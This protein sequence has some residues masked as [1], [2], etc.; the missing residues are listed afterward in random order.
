MHKLILT[1]AVFAT[2]LM[3]SLVHAQRPG[4]EG[5]QRGGQRGEGAQRG[6]QRGG[7]PGMQRGGGRGGM[8]GQRPVSPLMTALDADKDGKLSKEEIANAAKALAA[9]DKNEDGVLDTSELAPARGGRGGGGMGGDVTE[10]VNE[11]FER[12]ANKDGKLSKEEGGEQMARWF[13]YVDN[14]GDGFVS[15]EEAETSMKRFSGGG[16]GGRGGGGR[17]GQP[18]PKS[19]ENRPAFDDN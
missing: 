16:R 11:M 18:T 10:R 12:D 6:G 14:D 15:R 7:G 5:G 1:L 19:K 17:G 3:S 8:G 2:L 9:L 13:Q 4:G